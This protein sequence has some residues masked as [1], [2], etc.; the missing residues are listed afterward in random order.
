MSFEEP[1]AETPAFTVL[2][3]SHGYNEVDKYQ[4][5]LFLG[6]PT[7]T[8]STISVASKLALAPQGY[9]DLNGFALC[10]DKYICEFNPNSTPK[11]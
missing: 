3:P 6:E 4:T 8:C 10:A 11:G 7:V 9:V 5:K 1:E 2:N